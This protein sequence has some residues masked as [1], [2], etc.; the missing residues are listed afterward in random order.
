MRVVGFINAI[1]AYREKAEEYGPE[2]GVI[3]SD[4]I[5]IIR[6]AYSFQSFPTIPPG[7]MAAPTL[8]F[9]SGKFSDERGDFG[10]GAIVMEPTADIVLATTTDQAE[11]V[12]NDLIHRLDKMVG[13]RLTQT[14][15]KPVYLSNLVVE[16]DGELNKHIEKLGLILRAIN[17]A[18][19]NE[20]PLGFKRLAF[21]TPIM[22][23]APDQIT[24]LEQNDFIIERRVQ[25]PFKSNRFY[26]SAPMKTQDHVKVLQQI[27]KIAKGEA[28]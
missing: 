7:Q 18:H 3:L 17:E 8:T 28:S 20:S 23:V 9:G 24:T 27:E 22:H 16:F 5:E 6:T 1:V 14:A 12:L 13:F 26:C 21:G 10:V 15:K 4:L 11:L 2:R 25:E 19:P